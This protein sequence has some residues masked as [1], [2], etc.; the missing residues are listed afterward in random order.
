MNAVGAGASLF[1]VV[2]PGFD[3]DG[4]G[5]LLVDFN[6]ACG[7]LSSVGGRVHSGDGDDMCGEMA[8]VVVRNGC[9][10]DGGFFVAVYA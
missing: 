1:V 5:G 2:F 6:E 8:D 9:D 4:D 10:G 3:V 7:F